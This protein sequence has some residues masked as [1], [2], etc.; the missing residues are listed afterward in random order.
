MKCWKLSWTGLKIINTGTEL[1]A[2]GLKA[3]GETCDLCPGTIHFME[4]YLQL[5]HCRSGQG[6]IPGDLFN[7]IMVMKMLKEREI[8]RNKS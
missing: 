7:H 6:D 4:I 5:L 1:S 8:D 2:L 3:H